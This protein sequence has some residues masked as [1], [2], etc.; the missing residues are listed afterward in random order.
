MKNYIFSHQLGTASI[1]V[2][3][4]SPAVFDKVQ[5][6][7]HVYKLHFYSECFSPY[8]IRLKA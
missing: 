5:Y 3:A 2:S 1:K 7:G 6:K 4:M 8:F